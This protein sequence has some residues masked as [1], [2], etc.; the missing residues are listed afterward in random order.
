MKIK[1][2]ISQY[3]RDFRAIYQCEHCDHETQASGYDDGYFHNHVIPSME[4]E[5]CGKTSG[6]EYEPRATKYP[7]HK[8]V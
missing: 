2:I 3:R 5:A 7:D 8:V 1:Q 4:C 6:D